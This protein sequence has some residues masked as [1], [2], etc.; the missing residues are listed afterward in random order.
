VWDE[1][2]G[3]LVIIGGFAGGVDYLG[4][5][6]EYDSETDAWIELEIGE[7]QPTARAQHVAVWANDSILVHGGNF[8]NEV[9]RL[10]RD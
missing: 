6:W 9:W 1:A 8:T 7:P 10:T 2:Q 5:A 3:R 4:D